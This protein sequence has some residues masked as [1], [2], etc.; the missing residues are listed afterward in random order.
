MHP[1]WERALPLT[2][3]GGTIERFHIMFQDT[4]EE[5]FGVLEVAAYELDVRRQPVR[6]HRLHEQRSQVLVT[7]LGDLA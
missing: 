2:N 6:H 3:I 4:I 7:P 1:K 5:G